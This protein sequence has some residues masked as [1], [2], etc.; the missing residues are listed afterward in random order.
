[1]HEDARHLTELS[2]DLG[3]GLLQASILLITF[4][5]VLWALS[6][7]FAFHI[8][9]R[10]ITIP[11]YMVWAGIIYAGS[12]SLLSYWVGRSLVEQNASATLARPICAFRSCAST[13]TLMRYRSLAA[14]PTRRG[15]SRWI[16]RRCSPRRAASSPVLRISPGSPRA[17]AGSRSSRRY[18]SQR[19][20]I[21]RAASHS[22]AS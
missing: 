20:C 3:I 17:M 14:K 7:G 12:A 1:M 5:D 11:G 18:S 2:A 19:P 9:G 10:V 4:I 15:A 8:A 13:S 16:L 21:S 22:A 6:S